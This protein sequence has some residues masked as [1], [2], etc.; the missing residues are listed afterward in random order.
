[1]FHGDAHPGNIMVDKERVVLIHAGRIGFMDNEDRKDLRYLA[2]YFEDL[3]AA[4]LPNGTINPNRLQDLKRSK[5]ILQGLGP[6]SSFRYAAESIVDSSESHPVKGRSYLNYYTAFVSP[7]SVQ[8]SKNLLAGLRALDLLHRLAD[9]Y[10]GA[11]FLDKHG[12]FFRNHAL[13]T[14][15]IANRPPRTVAKPP[16]SHGDKIGGGDAGTPDRQPHHR[17][18]EPDSSP[19]HANRQWSTPRKVLAGMAAAGAAGGGILAVVIAATK[20]RKSDQQESEQEGL[21]LHEQWL[22]GS[23]VVYA[24]VAAERRPLLCVDVRAPAPAFG[25][26]SLNC[27]QTTNRRQMIQAKWS[28]VPCPTAVQHR[29]PWQP[30]HHSTGKRQMSKYFPPTEKSSKSFVP[31]NSKVLFTSSLHVSGSDRRSFM[32]TIKVMRM[33]DALPTSEMLD[34]LPGHCLIKD[35]ESR[36]LVGNTALAKLL[37]CKYPE[38]LAGKS[39]YD[40]P[41]RACELAEAFVEYDK[42]TLKAGCAREFFGFFDYGRGN[43]PFIHCRKQPYIVGGKTI[44]LSVHS[45]QIT[46]NL[47]RKLARNLGCID[48]NRPIEISFDTSDNPLGLSKRQLECLFLLLRGRTCREIADTLQLSPRTVE[49]YLESLKD[50]FCAQKRSELFDA[51]Y[52]LN[53]QHIIPSSMVLRRP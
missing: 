23:C 41:G 7:T 43:V 1:M 37:R 49:K 45:S 33:I 27:G 26:I 15:L 38:D 24:T 34:R 47:F 50:R 30:L 29:C 31:D 11:D 16:T 51:A 35:L 52:H 32:T 8:E 28:E 39:D 14:Q 36:Y 4:R 3:E 20:L 10:L 40:V 53:Y 13:G 18:V 46:P 48:V 25:P 9:D 12:N 44:G 19:E 42:K 22:S 6:R 21:S 5:E 17:P 2:A